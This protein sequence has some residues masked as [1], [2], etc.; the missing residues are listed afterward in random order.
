MSIRGGSVKV[1]FGELA[2]AVRLFEREDAVLVL[3]LCEENGVP[4]LAISI[5]SV[6]SVAQ[7]AQVDGHGLTLGPRRYNV[8]VA[9]GVVMV[10]AEG[11]LNAMIP[12]G[13]QLG[14]PLR[15]GLAIC[16][17]HG[18]A[19]FLLG[20]APVR[21]VFASVVFHGVRWARGPLESLQLGVHQIEH[22]IARSR[23]LQCCVALEQLGRAGGHQARRCEEHFQLR[24]SRRHI[25]PCRSLEDGK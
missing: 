3:A 1:N 9:V 6:S 16:V 15:H 2:G 23:L 12:V 10:L 14:L 5:Q 13:S 4:R 20:L 11:V 8:E 22:S 18:G 19:T 17:E 24:I 21:D 25:W 7:V